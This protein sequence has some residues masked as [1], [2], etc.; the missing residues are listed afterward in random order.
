MFLLGQCLFSFRMS[1]ILE[2][3]CIVGGGGGITMEFPF[4]ARVIMALLFRNLVWNDLISLDSGCV[5]GF[6]LVLFCRCNVSMR[7]ATSFL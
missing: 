7:S 2:S 3:Y 6:R 1:C 5:V 4:S